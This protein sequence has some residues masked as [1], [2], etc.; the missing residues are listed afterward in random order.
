MTARIEG[1]DSTVRQLRRIEPQLAR[2]SV[3]RLKAPMSGAVAD[4]RATVPA[5]P[6]SGTGPGR[7]AVSAKFG[8][9]KRADGS[10]NLASVALRGPR[11]SVA[12]DMAEQDHGAHTFTRNLNRKYPKASRWVWPTVEAH[13]GQIVA[14]LLEAVKDTERLLNQALRGRA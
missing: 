13:R 10:K 5:T 8:G 11:W 3:K 2:D 1:V 6:L 9:R 7:V 12:A 4:V 14:G